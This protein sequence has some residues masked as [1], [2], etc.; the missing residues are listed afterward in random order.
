[1]HNFCNDLE[2]L[3]LDLVV[4]ESG[5][6]QS[7]VQVDVLLGLEDLQGVIE[8]RLAGA[9]G[10]GHGDGRGDGRHAPPELVLG[11][12]AELVPAMQ[13]KGTKLAI[14]LV[15]RLAIQDTKQIDVL[16]GSKP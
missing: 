14:W 13:R 3:L 1:M 9:G 6:L 2:W 4:V 7:C 11:S 5:L 15:T 16:S 10:R 8:V 12:N